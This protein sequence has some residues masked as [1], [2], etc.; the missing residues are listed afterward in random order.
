MILP[1]KQCQMLPEIRYLTTIILIC[2]LTACNT[3]ERATGAL[4]GSWSN[5]DLE[6]LVNQRDPVDS[7]YK[8]EV[9]EGDWEQT[10][11]IKPIVTEFR[12]D[13]SYHSE[14]R[15]LQDSLIR[16]VEGVWK[17]DGDTL[18]LVEDGTATRYH[19]EVSGEKVIFRGWLDWDQD[20]MQDDLYSGR[21]RKSKF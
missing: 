19:M 11:N 16:E 18:I 20:G 5:I 14:Y 9:L 2:I 8:F 15:S 10:L 7:V 3:N 4:I 13:G 1:H 6:V 17:M 12:R 21:Q